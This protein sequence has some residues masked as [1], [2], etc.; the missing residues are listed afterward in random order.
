MDKVYREAGKMVMILDKASRHT[1]QEAERF[2]AELDIIVMGYPVEHSHTSPVEEVWCVL[3]RAMN[4]FLRYADKDAHLA[5]VYEFILVHKFDYNFK[6]CQ[7]RKP[8]KGI[9]RLFIKMD[10]T[11]QIPTLYQHQISSKS[12]Q[13]Q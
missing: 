4:H 12:A 5:A 11:R 10:G 3:K 6:K 9:M 2:F 13:K 7:K 1:S 8:P